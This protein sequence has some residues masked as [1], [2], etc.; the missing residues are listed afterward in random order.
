MRLIYYCRKYPNFDY[1]M[2]NGIRLNIDEDSKDPKQSTCFNLK[3][4]CQI[5]I[6]FDHKEDTNFRKHFN[7]N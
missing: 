5:H 4:K 6:S 1:S 2:V 3:S 7:K